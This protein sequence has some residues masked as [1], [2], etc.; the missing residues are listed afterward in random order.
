MKPDTAFTALRD[1]NPVS[2]AAS[3]AE[4]EITAAAFLSATKER[5]ERMETL[6]RTD[7]TPPEGEKSRRWQ[8]LVAVAAFAVVIVVGLAILTVGRNTPDVAPASPAPAETAVPAPPFDSPQ[9][10]AEAYLAAVEAGDYGAY[11]EILAPDGTDW[12]VTPAGPAETDAEH[13]EARFAWVSGI[14]TS[15]S[16]IECEAIADASVR[17]SFMMVDPVLETIA[18]DGAV[19]AGRNFTLSDEGLLASVSVD[20]VSHSDEQAEIIQRFNE[21]LMLN[22]PEAIEEFNDLWGSDP[23]RASGDEIVATLFAAAADYAKVRQG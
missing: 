7:Q 16:E 21:W 23:L 8:P 5:S 20:V 22:R 6:E 11:Q 4:T 14:T 2:D 19:L 9:A 1:A 10:A 12:E 15:I 13:I 17:C 18:G 3:F